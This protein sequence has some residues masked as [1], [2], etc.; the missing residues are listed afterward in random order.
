MSKTV[1]INCSPVSGLS[2]LSD[3]HSRRLTK[4]ADVRVALLVWGAG[5]D[6]RQRLAAV[7]I[8][9]LS[10]LDSGFSIRDAGDRG[11]REQM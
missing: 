9:R 10:D 5:I 8:I 11:Q 1:T 3:E 2:R 4:K 6:G 7:R